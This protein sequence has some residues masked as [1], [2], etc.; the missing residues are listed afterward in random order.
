MVANFALGSDQVKVS[1]KSITLAPALPLATGTDYSLEWTAQAVTDWAGNP[2]PTAG[3]SVF[4]TA[5]SAGPHF[6]KNPLLTPA[7]TGQKAAIDLNDAIAVLK[8]VVG[9]PVNSDGSGA[10]AAQAIAA[11]S[12]SNNSGLSSP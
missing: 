3:T 1:G 5:N 2:L 10:S 11:S 12:L 4:K 6:W 8:M 7:A 9:L